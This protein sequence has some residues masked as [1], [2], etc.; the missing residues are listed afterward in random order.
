MRG[1]EF[2]CVAVMIN[3]YCTCWWQWQK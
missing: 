2:D 1:S 3:T